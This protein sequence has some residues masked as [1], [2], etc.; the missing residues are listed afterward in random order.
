MD[1]SESLKSIAGTLAGLPLDTLESMLVTFD[2]LVHFGDPSQRPEAALLLQDAASRCSDPSI[3]DRI[4]SAAKSVLAGQPCAFT[5]EG[6]TWQQA[7]EAQ[8]VSAE[9][10]VE[11]PE[12]V[13]EL[14]EMTEI[15]GGDEED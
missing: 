3:R 14:D 1:T 10:W 8:T 9:R 12:P 7:A 2:T 5:P 11:P 6:L 13:Y 15:E 4:L